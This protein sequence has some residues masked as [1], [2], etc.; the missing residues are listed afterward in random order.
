MIIS[1]TWVTIATEGTGEVNWGG[2]AEKA[3]IIL[4]KSEYGVIGVLMLQEVQE[5]YE[6]SLLYPF[7]TSCTWNT[8]EYTKEYEG[9]TLWGGVILALV[10]VTLA[11]RITCT[12]I[13][14]CHLYLLYYALALVRVP[15][16]PKPIV[17]GKQG[18]GSISKVHS[19]S[20]PIL[21]V[22]SCT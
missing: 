6:N 16:N 15:L 13:A 8:L 2:S 1:T 4:R 9:D 21:L 7:C 12:P 3:R 14:S 22:P 18:Y 10:P 5:W 11:Y 19:L 17:R 20:V